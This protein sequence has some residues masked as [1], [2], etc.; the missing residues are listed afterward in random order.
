MYNHVNPVDLTFLC[1]YSWDDRGEVRVV[2]R[3][4]LPTCVIW[5]VSKMI[6]QEMT[7]YVH[8]L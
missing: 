3:A 6:N 7:A 4:K 5:I 2:V 1:N 8:H